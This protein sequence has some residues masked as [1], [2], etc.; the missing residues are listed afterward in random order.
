M[1]LIKAYFL[2]FSEHP[3]LYNFIGFALNLLSLM[4][5]NHN[6]HGDQFGIPSYF[7]LLNLLFVVNIILVYVVSNKYITRA[8]NE[9][10][11]ASE[12]YFRN[13]WFRGVVYGDGTIDIVKK[14]LWGKGRIYYV[15]DTYSER[16]YND[17]FTFNQKLKGRY[18]NTN[19]SIN[20]SIKLEFD[21]SC[22]EKE[23]FQR[24]YERSLQDKE[25]VKFKSLSLDDYVD[26]VF[27]KFND[28]LQPEL[29]A[30]VTKYALRE[31][32]EP[33]VLDKAT[34]MII[35][36]ERIFSNVK[37][38]KLCL[39]NLEFSSCKGMVEDCSL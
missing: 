14:S 5:V 37:N 4:I 23:I 29:D 6:H 34:D 31:V 16:S 28:K 9:I 35:F 22:D 10:A 36:P 11:S 20:V 33:Y 8:R 18:G 17:K 13:E 32:S 26:Y 19:M 21:S 24:L 38:V 1:K 30:L 3:I 2:F 27:K 25:S 7:N 39:S 12:E 15:L